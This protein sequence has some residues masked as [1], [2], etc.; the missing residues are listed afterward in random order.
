MCDITDTP[1]WARTQAQ[2]IK[3]REAMKDE[4]QRREV[5]RRK[6]DR[7]NRMRQ[8]GIQQATKKRGVRL[9]LATIPSIVLGMLT[10]ET[11]PNW[12]VTYSSLTA[13]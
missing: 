2:A 11:S 12:H 10:L 4:V 9:G 5:L 6:K 1:E 8:A 7:I 13:T 3:Q